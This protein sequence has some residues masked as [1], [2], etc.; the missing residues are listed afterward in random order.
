VV[1]SSGSEIDVGSFLLLEGDQSISATESQED[2]DNTFIFRF[3]AE[4]EP[5]HKLEM[6]YVQFIY[7]K[8]NRAKEQT[9]K[10][11]GIDRKTLYRKLQEIES[12]H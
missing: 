1:L 8:N 5:L 3:G 4:A 2:K 11:L 6:K 7:E 12:T 9:A 10:D